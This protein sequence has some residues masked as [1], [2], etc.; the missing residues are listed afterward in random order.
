M[1][2]DFVGSF[3]L[4]RD[5]LNG[6][7]NQ[8]SIKYATSNGGESRDASDSIKLGKQMYAAKADDQTS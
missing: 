5:Y 1:W 8:I 4:E 2:T 3:L 7:S 6:E